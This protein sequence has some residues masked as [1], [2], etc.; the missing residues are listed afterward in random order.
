MKKKVLWALLD[1]V[2][3]VVFNTVFFTLGGYEHPASVWLSYGFIHFA[4]VMILATPFLI[5][6]GSNAGV[7][8]FSMYSI[9]AV[10]FFIEF[11][12]GLVFIFM[13]A[14]SMKAALVTQVILAGI[15]AIVLLSNLIANEH[16]GDAADKKEKEAAYIKTASSR[17][18]ALIGRIEDKKASKAMEKAY[19]VLHASPTKTTASLKS[20]ETQITHKVALLEEAVSSNDAVSV[21][22]LSGEIVSLAEDRNRKLRLSD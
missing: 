19:D 4:Y 15:Y 13:R 16:T 5:R 2:F 20:L 10:Y 21:I 8:G 11:I 7:F 3:L 22:T 6:T 18:Q 9:S 17:V 14:D 12:A 1:F